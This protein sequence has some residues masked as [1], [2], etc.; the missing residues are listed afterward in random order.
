MLF[1]DRKEAGSLLATKLTQ[2]KGKKDII[3]LG[4][5]RG[6]VVVAY[7]IA[8]KLSFPL[9]VVTPRKIG[10]P[11]NPELALGSIME[12]GT[13]VFNQ[14]IINLLGVPQHFIAREIE[15]EKARAQQRLALY[16]Q[17][18]PLPDIKG[19]TIMLVDDGVAT[20]ST[21]LA[22]IKAMREAEA[23]SVIVA[24]PVSSTDAYQLVVE[25]ADEVI[26]PYVR[27]DFV[28]VGMYYQYFSQTEDGE[29]VQLLKEANQHENQSS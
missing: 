24:V 28:G 8:K 1:H 12:N 13:G 26:C 19:H 27:E 10:A 6:G 20:G 2:F 23:K 15:K 22:S 18:A 17:Y 16:R 3:V 5:A 14:H 9:N 11:D 25:A 7:E 21:M 4:L 29:V